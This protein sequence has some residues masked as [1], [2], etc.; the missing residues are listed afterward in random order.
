MRLNVG[1]FA[2]KQFAG[3][4]DSQLFNFVNIFATAVITL[5]RIAFSILV[6]KL[7]TLSFH[8]AAA[9]VIFRSD[10]FDMIF[11]TLIFICNGLP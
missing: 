9:G 4:I 3:A 2:L 11:L 1:V 8:Y 6:G 7:G 5:M 10:K